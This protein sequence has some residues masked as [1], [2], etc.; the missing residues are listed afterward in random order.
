MP[1]A[2][3]DAQTIGQIAAGEIVERPLSVVKE[4]VENAVDAAAS[5]VTVRIEEGGLR[6]IEVVD[7]GS[8]IP[9]EQLSLAVQRHATSKLALAAD[10]ESIDSLGF[11]GE[12]LASIAAVSQLTIVTRTKTEQ[13]GAKVRAHAEESEPVEACAA[14]LGTAVRAADLFAE[15]PVRREYLRSPSA[16]FNRISGWLSMFALGHPQITFTLVHDGKEIWVMPGTTELRQRLA[17]VFGKPAAESLIPLNTEAASGLSGD[18]SGFISSPGSDRGDR[19]MQLLFVNGRLLRS[20]LLSG[21]WTAAY[22]TFAMIGRHPYGVLF[23]RL[24]AGH[25]DPNVHP[26]KSDVRL[27]FSHQVFDAVKRT[28]SV[29]LHAQATQ[30]FRG[31]FPVSLAPAAMDTSLAHLQ[32]LFETAPVDPQEPADYGAG[33]RLR[34]LAQ[35][36]L[37]YI[38]A[39]DGDSLIL[40]DQHAAHERIAYE[41]IVAAARDSAASEPLLVPLTFELDAAQSTALGRA[42]AMLREGGLDIEEFGERSYRILATPAGYGA[43]QFDVAGFLDDLGDEP[44]ARDVHERVWASLACHSV[45]TAGERLEPSEMSTLLDRLQICENPMH[46]PHGRPTIVRLDS[47]AIGRLFKRL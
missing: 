16:E 11:R 44:K 43:R 5:R 32:S 3:L 37:T 13:L 8:G 6:S 12:G 39:T 23:L 27:R 45:T 14:P 29:T 26:T 36:A 31:S 28:I 40:V 4:L 24:P 41:R 18:L 35:L 20:T 7:D 15:V 30:S 34:V 46:C 19:R 47:D 17:M 25:V 38:L 10:L 22:S 1:I 2:L 21:A 42:L 9:F 33:S